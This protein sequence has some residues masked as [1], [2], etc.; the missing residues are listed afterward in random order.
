MKKRVLVV[1]DYE[2]V[3][4]AVLKLLKR[5]GWD[6]TG[7][8][9]LRDAKAAVGP[10]DLVIA[11]VRLPNGDGRHLREIMVGVPFLSISGFPYEA[12]D[13]VKPFTRAKLFAAIDL[14][15]GVSK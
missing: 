8:R 3:L 6:A 15:L 9:S 1:D 11:D 14:K 10:W 13:L 4:D 5:A 12:P 7:A 2:L